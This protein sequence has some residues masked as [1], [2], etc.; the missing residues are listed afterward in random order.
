MRRWLKGWQDRRMDGWM[1]ETDKGTV[2]VAIFTAVQLVHHSPIKPNGLSD[3][4]VTGGADGHTGGTRGFFCLYMC[5]SVQMRD[6]ECVCMCLSLSTCQ[7]GLMIEWLMSNWT[8]AGTAIH[9]EVC[10]QICACS[11][12]RVH[13]CTNVSSRRRVDKEERCLHY[14]VRER[15]R[16][17]ERDKV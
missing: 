12:L 2:K 16:E 17:K 7:L 11:S 9:D 13:V 10:G 8:T 4:T 1:K 14:F 5:V 6:G 3:C 15:G